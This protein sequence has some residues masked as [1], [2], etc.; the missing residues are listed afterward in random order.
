MRTGGVSFAQ[1][2]LF[3]EP[4]G[5]ATIPEES[6]APLLM[7]LALLFF[8]VTF[9]FQMVW[10]AVGL[11]FL[12]FLIGCFWMWPRTEKEVVCVRPRR[13]FRRVPS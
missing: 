3:A 4:E 11:L 8:F 5:I 13:S 12:S 6:I 10:T 9:A 7:S 1:R 2:S